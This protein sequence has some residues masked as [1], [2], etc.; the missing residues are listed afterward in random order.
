MDADICSAS[1]A[2][3]D[4]DMSY[5]NAH[6]SERAAPSS[7]HSDSNSHS[8]SHLDSQSHSSPSPS[9]SPSFSSESE[10]YPLSRCSS[11]SSLSSAYSDSD[12]SDTEECGDDARFLVG[13][14]KKPRLFRR[15]KQQQQQQQ[16]CE[17][18]MSHQHD[19][20]SSHSR[21][22]GNSY[23]DNK[24]ENDADGLKGEEYAK[25]YDDDADEWQD[26]DDDDDESECEVIFE[27]NVTFDDPLATDIVT[28]VPVAPSC[29]SRVEWT[30]LKARERLER[31]LGFLGASEGEEEDGTSQDL[32]EER[33]EDFDGEAESKRGGEARG[34]AGDGDDLEAYVLDITEAAAQSVELERPR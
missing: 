30:A 20:D 32:L 27:R 10:S 14:L 5:R 18:Q 16:G 17:T 31:R 11:I 6:N 9:S 26:L 7:I 12:T 19:Y 29:R 3:M 34:T 4:W 22:N 2:L 21:N 13:I 8:H 15:G 1:R 23:A 33:H 24:K 25:G 28:G